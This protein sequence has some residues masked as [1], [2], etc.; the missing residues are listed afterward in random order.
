MRLRL[1]ALLLILLA[2]PVLADE[3]PLKG[4]RFLAGQ[5][6]IAAPSMR[7]PRFGESV[8]YMVEHDRRGAMG[9]IV[10]KVLGEGPLKDLLADAGVEAKDG[11][12]D[13]VELHAGGP[14]EPRRVF[15]LHGGDW[16]GAETEKLAENLY[17]T[18]TRDILE[19][20]AEGKGPK[21]FRVIIGYSGWAPGQLEREMARGDWIS[22][23]ADAALVF[24]K[25][26]AEKWRR[27]TKK[28]GVGL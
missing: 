7:D 17:L 3:A 19:A 27:A 13:M 22:G 28:G 21:A 15:I 23:P 14:V 12:E 6:L 8:I 16:K 5:F 9:L 2:P 1:A 26:E 18:V 11:L 10:N 4:G 25:Q 24:D 20:L